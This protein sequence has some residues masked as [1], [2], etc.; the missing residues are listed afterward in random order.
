[1]S[2]NYIPVWIEPEGKPLSQEIEV[3]VTEVVGEKVFGRRV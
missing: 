1:V 2:R 3:E